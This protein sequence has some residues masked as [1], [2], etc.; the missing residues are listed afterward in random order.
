M[1]LYDTTKPHKEIISN[2]K[3][4]SKGKNKIITKEDCTVKF[5]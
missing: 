5:S 4:Q 3:Y 2:D 1:Q